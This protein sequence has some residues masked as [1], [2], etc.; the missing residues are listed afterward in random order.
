MN[1]PSRPTYSYR[2]LFWLAHDEH[3]ESGG[4]VPGT[5]RELVGEHRYD[6]ALNWI[7]AARNSDFRTRPFR[8]L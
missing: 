8:G 2:D 1:Q 5:V 4:I 3:V 7:G 6:D